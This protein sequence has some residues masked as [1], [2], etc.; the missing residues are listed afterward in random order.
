MKKLWDIVA[1]PHSINE[2]VAMTNSNVIDS[3]ITVSSADRVGA[4]LQ[5]LDQIG[6]MT[7]DLYN[8]FSHLEEIDAETD[9]ALSGAYNSIDDLYAK[10]DEK[11]DV[12][13]VDLDQYDE[14]ELDE[15]FEH[16]PS[17]PKEKDVVLKSESYTPSMSVVVECENEEQQ[18][19][20]YNRMTAEGFTC[21]IM[22]V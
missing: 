7:D 20:I 21:K 17:P 22:S 3:P 8:T 1:T 4:A 19:Q 18:R 13:P 12:I 6:E 16:K 10:I 5:K 15:D 14:D 2:D 11:Y 9:A